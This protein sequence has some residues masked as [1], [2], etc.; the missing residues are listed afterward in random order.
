MAYLDGRPV[1]AIGEQ[2]GGEGKWVRYFAIGYIANSLK[3]VAEN[4]GEEWFASFNKISI[5][6]E[7]V[8][9]Q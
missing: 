4:G 1:L 9:G 3:A 2:P 6:R 5:F 7:P 8:T